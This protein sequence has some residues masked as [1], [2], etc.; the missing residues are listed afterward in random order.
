MISTYWF[1]FQRHEYSDNE[2]ISHC[3]R[4]IKIFYLDGM[5]GALHTQIVSR[6][7][8]K[9]YHNKVGRVPTSTV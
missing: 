8:Y 2:L 1:L 7:S 3:N 9:L 6:H 4:L 5:S